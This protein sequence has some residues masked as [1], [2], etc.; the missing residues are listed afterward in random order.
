[1]GK[2]WQL[3][4]VQSRRKEKYISLADNTLNYKEGDTVLSNADKEVL[5]TNQLNG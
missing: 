1:M 4:F 5:K 3:S 2:S